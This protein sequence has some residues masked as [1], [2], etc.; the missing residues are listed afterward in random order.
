MF[1]KEMLAYGRKLGFSEKNC[2]DAIQDVFID[3]YSAKKK[4]AHVQNIEFYLLHSLKNRLFDIY[5]QETKINHINYEDVVLQN[6]ESVIDRMINHERQLHL[7][8]RITQSLQ[9]LRPIQRKIIYLRYQLNLSF[10]EIAIFLDMTPG[11]IKKS[12]Y[13]ALKKMRS[14]STDFSDLLPLFLTLLS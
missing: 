9:S 4:L 10:E 8:N 12:Y 7:K 14:D 3:L 13:R 5:H 6:E 11:A 1:F 2:E